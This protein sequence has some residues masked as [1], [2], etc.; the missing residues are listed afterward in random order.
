MGL[1]YVLRSKECF[2]D[3][4]LVTS[5]PYPYHPEQHSKLLDRGTFATG[6]YRET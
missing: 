1:L 2:I 6:T 4:T 5:A 3:S